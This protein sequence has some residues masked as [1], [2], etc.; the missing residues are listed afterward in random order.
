MRLVNRRR[1]R[2]S[3]HCARRRR[4]SCVASPRLSD[5]KGAGPQWRAISTR[6]V[7]G[8]RE[9]ARER[10]AER[11]AHHLRGGGGP[12]ELAA[13]AGRAQ[14]RHSPAPRLERDLPVGEACAQGLHLAASSPSWPAGSRRRAPARWAGCAN[15]Q[16][17]LIIAGSP[18]SQV[19]MLR[20]PLR[21]GANGSGGED[22]GGIVAIRQRIEHAGGALVAVA[23]VGTVGGEG[24]GAERLNSWRRPPS[25]A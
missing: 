4:S 2:A 12:Q 7:A 14:A 21:K 23:G 19:A 10:H 11:F 1:Q 3:W 24:D 15:R 8:R 5:N 17:H 25:A 18:L 13:A 9:R 20:T 22:A 16:R 6:S